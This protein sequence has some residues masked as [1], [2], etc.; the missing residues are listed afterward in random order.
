MCI[1]RADAVNVTGGG[2]YFGTGFGGVTQRRTQPI[3]ASLT[4]S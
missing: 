3:N 2:E 4:A 1:Q